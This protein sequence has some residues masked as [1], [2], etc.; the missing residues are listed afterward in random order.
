MN[1]FLGLADGVATATTTET[2]IVDH[3]LTGGDGE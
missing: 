3:E 2:V 1:A